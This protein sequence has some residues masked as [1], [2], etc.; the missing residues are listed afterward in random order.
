MLEELLLGAGWVGPEGRPHTR[1]N[2]QS[3]AQRGAVS[4]FSP[5]HVQ[6]SR[7]SGGFVSRAGVS[8]VEPSVAQ[9]AGCG[10]GG[11]LGRSELLVVLQQSWEQTVTGRCPLWVHE[12]YLG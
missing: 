10:P 6:H 11:K 9:R 3:A 1:G 12:S 5:G 4:V 8:G 7:S 2:L